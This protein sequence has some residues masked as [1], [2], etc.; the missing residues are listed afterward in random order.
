MTD[1]KSYDGKSYDDHQAEATLIVCRGCQQ[2]YYM[3]TPRAQCLRC[4]PF[5]PARAVRVDVCG[6]VLDGP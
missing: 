2:P 1:G 3:T 4:A 6:R 5:T